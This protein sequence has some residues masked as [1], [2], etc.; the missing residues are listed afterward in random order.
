LSFLSKACLPAVR[1][2]PRVAEALA[3]AQGFAGDTQAF[4]YFIEAIDWR[5]FASDELI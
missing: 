4:T 2:H 1:R 5:T 3:E